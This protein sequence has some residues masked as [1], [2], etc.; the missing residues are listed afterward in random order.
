MEHSNIQVLCLV[1]SDGKILLGMKKRGFGAGRYNGLGGKINPLE[2]LRAGARREV[3]EEAGIRVRNLKKCGVITF[4]SVAR[5]SIVMHVYSTS[6]FMG[7]PQESEEMR[8]VWFRFDRIP[9]PQMWSDDKHWL[10]HVLQGKRVR[11][12]FWFD[13]TDT[14]VAKDIRIV[15]GF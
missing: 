9:Y 1:I 3:E 13:A 2:T 11:A 8:P 12:R 14:V 5:A 10:P 4:S 6:D 7:V 15:P